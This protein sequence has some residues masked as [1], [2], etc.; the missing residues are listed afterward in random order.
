MVLSLSHH[1]VIFTRH[2]AEATHGARANF[3]LQGCHANVPMS[4]QDFIFIGNVNATTRARY[5]RDF[6]EYA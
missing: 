6:Q 1:D 4:Q 2:K 5:L 3:R